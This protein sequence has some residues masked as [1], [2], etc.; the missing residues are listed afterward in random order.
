MNLQVKILGDLHESI[1]QN[2]DRK[3]SLKVIIGELQREPK[4]TLSDNEVI[5]VLKKLEK[6]ETEVLHR[7]KKSSSRYMEIL[8]S[9]IPQTATRDEVE[10]WKA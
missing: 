1:K 3:E 6:S 8:Q 7:S 2:D 5:R 10:N 9:Y 4:K